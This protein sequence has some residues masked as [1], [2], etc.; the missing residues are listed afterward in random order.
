MSLKIRQ[1]I[2]TISLYKQIAYRIFCFHPQNVTRFLSNLLIF[3]KNY[4]LI[5]LNSWIQE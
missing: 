5:D 3:K 1:A 4:F 2:L